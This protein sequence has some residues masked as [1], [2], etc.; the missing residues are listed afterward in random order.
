MMVCGDFH[1][2]NLEEKLMFGDFLPVNSGNFDRNKY[3]FT[4]YEI[5][6]QPSQFYA[7]DFE[8]LVIR[9]I[10]TYET[11]LINQIAA[12]FESFFVPSRIFND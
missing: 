4:V 11:L 10:I 2:L 7:N 3:N 12:T 8:K 9:E 5:F 6:I 1:V